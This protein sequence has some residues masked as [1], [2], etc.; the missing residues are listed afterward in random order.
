[1]NYKLYPDQES[2]LNVKANSFKTEQENHKIINDRE[3]FTAALYE[4][5][6]EVCNP[7]SQIQDDS[8]KKEKEIV[9]QLMDLKAINEE[10]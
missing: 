5:T 3:H 8:L 2:Y 4:T 9:K 6:S 1:M 7:L 10:P